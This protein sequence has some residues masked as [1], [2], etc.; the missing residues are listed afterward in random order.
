MIEIKALHKV[1]AL[2]A[3][4]QRVLDD[5]QF[6]MAEGEFVSIMGPSGSGKSS[7][8]AVLG[9]LDSDWR[10]EYHFAG[11]ALHAMKESQRKEFARAR[12]GLVFQQYHLLDDLNVAENIDLPLDYLGVARSERR[13]RVEQS[14]SR[15]G[16]LDK[17]AHY[18]R[19]LSGGQQQMVAVAR[20]VAARP[21]LLL[22]D[23]PTGALHSSQGEMIMD[24]LVELNRAGTS[25]IQV[26]HNPEY[27]ARA[28]RVMQMRDGR[29]CGPP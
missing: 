13:L 5:V 12:I 17:R 1:Y 27:A 2:P 8:L 18:P 3:G 23:E 6:E 21:R 25:I 11:V 7:L 22:A 16:L 15:F 14:L 4:Q 28:G 10:G 26:T 29:L 24:L 9:L 20:A 19:Q